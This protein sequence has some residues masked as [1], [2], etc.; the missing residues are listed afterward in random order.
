MGRSPDEKDI[1]SSWKIHVLCSVVIP[2]SGGM[3]YRCS[4]SLGAEIPHPSSRVVFNRRQTTTFTSG[5]GPFLVSVQLTSLPKE[6]LIERPLVLLQ[7]AWIECIVS[8][9][10][11]RYVE[12]KWTILHCSIIKLGI[13]VKL[14]NYENRNVP[15]HRELSVA[16]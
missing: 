16:L 8:D 5:S 6:W 3:L 12:H 13:C 7:H 10:A 1:G 2:F 15:L 4:W 14:Y 11:Q 9:F